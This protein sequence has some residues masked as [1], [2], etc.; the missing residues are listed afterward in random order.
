MENGTCK[1]G[2]GY[3]QEEWTVVNSYMSDFVFLQYLEWKKEQDDNK[4]CITNVIQTERPD[5]VFTKGDVVNTQGWKG[6][7]DYMTIMV[8]P[9]NIEWNN[10]EHEDYF[11]KLLNKRKN[12]KN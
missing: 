6:Y 2:H 12:G 4:K 9:D 1:G 7:K 11:K 8:P 10:N 5:H 3:I